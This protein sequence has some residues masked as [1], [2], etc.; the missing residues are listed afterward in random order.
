MLNEIIKEYGK[1]E[2]YEIPTIGWSEENQLGRFGEYQYWKNHII[3][4]RVF[5]TDR[6]SERAVK[7]IIFHEYTHQLYY[8]H[9]SDFNAR[10]KLFEG[11]EESDSELQDYINSI[12]DI[13]PAKA[14]GTKLNKVKT[15]V[16]KIFMDK[17]DNDSYWKNIYFIDHYMLVYA[18]KNLPDKYDGKYDQ[19]IFTVDLDRDTYIVGWAKN[20]RIHSKKY[21]CDLTKYGYEKM[22]YHIKFRRDDGDLLLPGGCLSLGDT[23][24]MPV[25]YIKSGIC[26]L[27]ELGRDDEENIIN[28]INNYDSDLHELGL[29]DNA[30]DSVPG[31]DIKDV[32]KIID[33]ARRE[34]HTMKRVWIM[35]K[36]VELEQSYRTYIESAIAKEKCSLL[37]CA[38]V[39]VARALAYS[40]QTDYKGVSEKEAKELFERCMSVHRKFNADI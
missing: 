19:V 5:N 21:I 4:S 3:V 2:G 26:E 25:S 37:D 11:Y 24:E 12:E 34:T 23:K 30:I 8:E 40:P 1:N 14:L 33:M 16:V 7:S 22:D 31:I 27:S 36:A 9:N 17:N 29:C 13:T 39:D 18:A 28:I 6:I 32:S 38:M 20:V 10:M 35:N 15:M